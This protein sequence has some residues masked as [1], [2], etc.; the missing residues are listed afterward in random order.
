ML[1]QTV[2]PK[3]LQGPVSWHPNSSHWPLRGHY[4]NCKNVEV[5]VSGD[6]WEAVIG[7]VLST[8]L[9][10][11]AAQAFITAGRAQPDQDSFWL[12]GK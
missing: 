4:G 8:A 10:S 1:F 5:V 7:P 11:S 2:L 12:G 6:V 9:S 3:A